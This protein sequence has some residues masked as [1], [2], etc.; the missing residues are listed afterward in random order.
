MN[1]KEKIQFRAVYNAPE[2][3]KYFLT[4]VYTHWTPNTS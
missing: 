2:V 3:Y 4:M 1:R